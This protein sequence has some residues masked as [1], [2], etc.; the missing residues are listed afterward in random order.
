MSLADFI[1]EKPT[2][3][4]HLGI[5]LKD[6]DQVIGDLWVYLIENNRMASVAI[7]ISRECHGK[8]Y[9]TESLAAMT[10][11]CFTKTE[12]QRLWAAVEVRNI[13][14]DS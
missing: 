13:A 1:Y 7:R 2:K 11:F 4:F 6:E 9:G 12:L 10:E 8:G 3:S 5:A 14:S